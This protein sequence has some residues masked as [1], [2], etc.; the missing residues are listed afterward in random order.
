[1]NATKV[2][3]PRAKGRVYCMDGEEASRPDLIQGVCIIVGNILFV[4]FDSGA[5]HSFISMDCVYRLKL[6]VSSLPFDLVITTPAIK[7]LT[8]NTGCLH[9]PVII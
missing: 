5:T 9:C 2:A 6:S 4:L 3:R 1:M 8:A 7:T